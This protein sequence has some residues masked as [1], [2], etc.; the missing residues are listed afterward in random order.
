MSSPILPVKED[1]SADRID[2]RDLHSGPV[3]RARDLYG[4]IMSSIMSIPAQ[5]GG[6]KDRNGLTAGEVFGGALISSSLFTILHNMESISV[7]CSSSPS[8][9]LSIFLSKL[10][11]VVSVVEL[12]IQTDVSWS[13][14]RLLISSYL[15]LSVSA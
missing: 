11:Q 10:A 8:A 6:K 1:P 14:Y 4:L 5:H 12:F 9:K 3:N 15:P 7:A 13:L 2:E